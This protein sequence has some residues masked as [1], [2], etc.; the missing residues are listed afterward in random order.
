MLKLI[1]QKLDTL[2]LKNQIN[3]QVVLELLI[4]FLLRQYFVKSS[5]RSFFPST[6]QQIL[7][8]QDKFI[9]SSE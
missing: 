7:A 3:S 6:Y 1:L 8:H 4:Q 5:M 2:N 9:C